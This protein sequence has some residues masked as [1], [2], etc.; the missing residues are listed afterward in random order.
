MAG[1]SEERWNRY[2]FVSIVTQ[3]V[4][5]FRYIDAITD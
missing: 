3:L 1:L 4:L 2:T 5:L